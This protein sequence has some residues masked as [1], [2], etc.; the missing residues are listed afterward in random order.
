MNAAKTSFV[1]FAAALSFSSVALAQGTSG[2][3]HAATGG[4]LMGHHHAST[5]PESILRGEADV[6]RAAGEADYNHSA[7]T[8][9]REGAFSAHLDNQIKYAETFFQ[10]RA[11]NA[12]ARAVER[13][14]PPCPETLARFNRERTPCRLASHQLDP[15]SAGIRWPAAFECKCFHSLRGRVDKLFAER[16]PDNSGVGSR[17]Y[18]DVQATVCAMRYM[19]KHRIH[20]MDSAE[21]VHARK[22]IDSVGYEARH[23]LMPGDAGGERLAGQGAPI[24][25]NVA[26]AVNEA[27][28]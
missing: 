11:I 21:Y 18:R 14:M 9:I 28:N 20:E 27:I 24:N 1:L 5:A 8:L 10:K 4:Q 16:S 3:P 15:V 23:P 12:A 25:E 17:N 2:V 7:A 26:A 22:F 13:G 6:I 19:L